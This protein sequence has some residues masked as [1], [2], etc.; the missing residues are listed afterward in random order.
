MVA[1]VGIWLDITDWITL[2]LLVFP[3]LTP[4]RFRPTANEK[5][6]AFKWLTEI[7]RYLCRGVSWRTPGEQ[8]TSCSTAARLQVTGHRVMTFDPALICLVRNRMLSVVR[9]TTGEALSSTKPHQIDAEWQTSLLTMQKTR[10]GETLWWLPLILDRDHLEH[11]KY[12]V[13]NGYSSSQHI[14]PLRELTGH[15]GIAQC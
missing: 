7:R 8:T 2:G 12:R 3:H 15:N 14:S 1:L 4:T 9:R 10:Q 5:F 11:I 13:V 6:P